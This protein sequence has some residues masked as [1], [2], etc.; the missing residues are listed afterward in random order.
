MTFALS[1]GVVLVPP[2]VALLD[3]ICAENGSACF[4]QRNTCF[5]WAFFI[6]LSNEICVENEVHISSRQIGAF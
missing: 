4:I 2:I 1:W 3:E 5:L 6:P